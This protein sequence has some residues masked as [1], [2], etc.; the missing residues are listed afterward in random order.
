MRRPDA[1][2]LPG[3][4]GQGGPPGGIRGPAAA[5]RGGG[6]TVSLPSHPLAPSPLSLLSAFPLS[7]VFPGGES[8]AYD[9][10]GGQ[11]VPL[12]GVIAVGVIGEVKRNERAKKE[13]TTV[14]YTPAAA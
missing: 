12:I 14:H 7:S 1:S 9:V 3:R 13:D 8:L 5:S 6:V 11:F 2:L 10:N 4:D